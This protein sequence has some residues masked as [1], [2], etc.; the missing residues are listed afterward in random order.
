MPAF[1]QLEYYGICRDINNSRDLHRR[2]DVFVGRAW[3]GV[4]VFGGDGFYGR[5]AWGHAAD[6]ARAQSFCGVDRDVAVLAGRI[7]FVEDSLAVCACLYSR[8]IYGRNDKFADE[9]L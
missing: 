8:S 6:R 5:N 4:G 7:F 2:R 1:R 3:R 9:C